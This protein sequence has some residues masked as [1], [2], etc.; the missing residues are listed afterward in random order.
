VLVADHL[1]Q[2]EIKLAHR[3]SKQWSRFAGIP[4]FTLVVTKALPLALQPF[5]PG[6]WHQSKAQIPPWINAKKERLA[7]HAKVLIDTLQFLPSVLYR[8]KVT[9]G[10]YGILS[11]GVW[12]AY[13]DVYVSHPYSHRPLVEFCI[14]IP[15]SQMQRSGETRSLL[16]RSLK[17]I[18]PET[19]L[20]R[21]GKS[22][23][24]EPFA[25]AMQRDH[26]GLDDVENWE[27]CLRHYVR[28]SYLSQALRNWRIGISQQS[29]MFALTVVSV[30]RFLRSLS[31]IYGN[32][33][34]ANNVVVAQV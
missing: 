4:Y 30:E 17:G 1:R 14:G 15:M 7:D 28:P 2:R 18:L 31:L 8:I 34:N 27:V 32:I 25:R 3:T 23:I 19:T 13:P 10:L 26:T 22:T 9:Q 24:E 16:R 12:N 11:T 29:D 21:K 20:H 6:S 33:H 5:I